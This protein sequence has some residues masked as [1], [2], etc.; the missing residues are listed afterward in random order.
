MAEKSPRR[1]MLEQSLA[2]DPCDTFLRYGLAVQCLR[3]G[4]VEEGRERL[5]APDR[6]PPRRPDRGLPAAR[7]VVP[8]VG[9]DERAVEIAPARGSPRP[10]P[11]A[12]GTRRPRWKACSR[13]SA[14]LTCDSR[15]GSA[16]ACQQLGTQ[17]DASR[18]RST[19]CRDQPR[20]DGAAMSAIFTFPNRILF[21]DG[22]RSSLAAELARLGVHA[23]AGRDRPGARGGGRG[24]RG[25]RLARRAAV[26][27]RDVQAN[28]TEADVLAGLE[29]LP[30]P[31][32]AT[33]LI[34]LGG[35]SPIDAAKAIRL[36]ATH[37]GRLADYDLTAGGPGPDHAEPAAD[38]RHPDHGRHRQRG[39]PG[40]LD[41][42]PPDRPQDHRRSARTCCRAWRSATPS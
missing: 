30:R 11:G 8:G 4:D 22:A 29:R 20:T 18:S 24:R 40:R 35:G 5:L 14:E 1:V 41:P 26:V 21:G 16:S 12:T 31:T 23:P 10:A 27:F 32:A 33:A 39:G 9:R 3:E 28:P 19:L 42:A 34:G 25:R 15:V 2:E 36:L 37:P 17:L 7:P 6:R 13:S 38:G